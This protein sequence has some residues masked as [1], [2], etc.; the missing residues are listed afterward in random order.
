MSVSS[1]QKLMTV[2]IQVRLWM[3]GSEAQTEL[4]KY[5]SFG[6]LGLQMILPWTLIKVLY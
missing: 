4:D 3:K 2:G 5:I 1:L 6:M